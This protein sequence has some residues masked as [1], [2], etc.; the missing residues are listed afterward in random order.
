MNDNL[1]IKS[2][3]LVKH[4]TKNKTILEI[5]EMKRELYKT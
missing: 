5:K 1:V 2:I 3:Y 4:G